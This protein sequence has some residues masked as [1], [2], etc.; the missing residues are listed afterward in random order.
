[1]KKIN[2]ILLST[3]VIIIFSC[4]SNIEIEKNSKGKVEGALELQKK[5]VV[6]SEDAIDAPEGD[7]RSIEKTDPPIDNKEN[8]N[9]A[10]TK[11]SSDLKPNQTI[12]L[13]QIYTDTIEFSAYDDNYDYFYLMGKKNGKAVS[14]IYSWDWNTD[15][16]YNFTD[17]D[18]IKVQWKMDSIF[19]AGE[20]DALD[21]SERAIDAE[22]IVF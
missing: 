4:N 2:I 17:G 15:N 13:N 6:K 18:L 20:G 12:L 19:I 10:K 3:L 11:F 7:P 22:K 8:A 9:K 14:L 21:F 5:V 16:Q 1:M